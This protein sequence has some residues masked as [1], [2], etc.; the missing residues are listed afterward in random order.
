MPSARESEPLPTR[1]ALT[2]QA[3]RL[4]ELAEAN[5]PRFPSAADL[6]TRQADV[7]ARL[8]KIAPS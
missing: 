1:E 4:L 6:Y 8:A 2:Q 5:T 7:Y 3:L